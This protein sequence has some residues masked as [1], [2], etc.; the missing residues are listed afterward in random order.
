MPR[1]LQITTPKE[2]TQK[3]IEKVNSSSGIL[4][5]TA[6]NSDDKDIITIT[7]LDKSE[8]ELLLNIQEFIKNKN[9]FIQISEPSGV[10][11]LSH[12]EEISNDSSESSWE[13]MEFSIAKESNAT[14]NA[15]IT[16]FASGFIAAIGIAENSIHIVIASMVITP[17]FMPFIRISLGIVSKSNSFKRGIIS[18]LKLY[19]SFIVGVI[20]ASLILLSM[21]INPVGELSSYLPGFS[22]SSYWFTLSLRSVLI[23]ALASIAGV[24][25]IVSRKSILTAGVM[26]ALSLVPSAT[27]LGMGVTTMDFNIAFRGAT[28]FFIDVFIIIFFSAIILYYKKIKI[29]KRNM[30][31]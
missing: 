24:I 9:I 18:S 1:S 14:L 19:I 4:N 26:I 13:E 16:M 15:I 17:G 12:S 2:F 20:I 5:V 30:F 31:V 8:A 10:I 11:S 23:S 29:H 27:L 22:L 3:I 25:L 28:R 6:Q 21:G 7:V